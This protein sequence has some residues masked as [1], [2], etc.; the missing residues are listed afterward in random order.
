VHVSGDIA[1]PIAAGVRRPCIIIPAALAETLS[2][3][4]LE[5]IIA[6]ERAHIRRNDILA[7]AVQRCIEAALYFNPCAWIIGRQVTR[8]REAACDDLAV[9]ATGDEEPYVRCLARL[10]GVAQKHVPL[11]T[12]SAIG[13]RHALVD[14]IERLMSAGSPTQITPN[15]YT[16]GGIVI[17]FAALT[18][19]LQAISPAA[20]PVSV[21]AQ[22]P[23]SNAHYQS[24]VRC[25]NPNAPAMVSVPAPPRPSN[26]AKNARGW[27]TIRVTVA[28]NG[29]VTKALVDKSSGNAAV[30]EAALAAAEHSTF[31][32]KM[33]NCKPVP[34]TYLFKVTMDGH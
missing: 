34:G 12:P 18:L 22:S 32:P 17:V 13:S 3:A 15:Y 7:N 21:A 26:G 27:A 5:R 23:Q 28:A 4:D 2:G 8:A 10:M 24:N 14:R 19:A 25:E 33:L 1:I 11:A 30:N 20:A 16:I 29:K 31:T 6:H 9:H